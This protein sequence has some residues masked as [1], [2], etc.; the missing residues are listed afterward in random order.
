MKRS[1]LILVIALAMPVALAVA[2]V[3]ADKP[4]AKP[5]LSFEVA[6]VK[7]AGP[8]DPQKIMSGQQ[9]I[10]MESDDARVTIYSMTLND[11]V[12]IA[13]K[14]KPYQISGPSWLSSGMGAD[15]FEVRAT[16]PEGGK[17]D[18]VPE[19]MQTLLVERFGLRFHREKAEQNVYALVVGKNGLK[20]KD[21]VPD[22][23]TDV[24]SAP[25]NPS[26]PSIN[27]NGAQ[28]KMEGNPQTGMTVRGGGAGMG[29]IKMTMNGNTMHMENPKMNMEMFMAML[30]RFV[31]RP[32][33]DTTDLKGF[34]Q[35]TIDISMEEMMN[36][37]RSM[38]AGPMVAGPRAAAAGGVPGGVPAGP[39]DAASEPGGSIFQ[40]VQRLGLKLEPRKAPVD[41]IVIDSLERLAGGARDEHQARLLLLL[42]LALQALLLGGEGGLRQAEPRGQPL[43]G[44]VLVVV[45]R[46][47]AH[48]HQ[49][50][51]LLLHE[52]LQDGRDHH[53]VERAVVLHQDAPVGAHGQRGA[54]LG[55]RLLR[56]D[57]RD[58]HLAAVLLLEPKPL[59]DGDL[60]EGIHLVVHAFG[61][62]ARSVGLHLDLRLGVLDALR[63]DQDLEGHGDSLTL[64]STRNTRS[65]LLHSNVATIFD[66]GR[67]PGSR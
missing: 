15:R 10:G 66:T 51:L 53:R 40:S 11:L 34:Y 57:A 35:I 41:K 31:D 19:M 49:V 33:V 30:S 65:S 29:P 20:L 61:D 5:A 28:V 4:A 26:V 23:A 38:G 62:D 47:L 45:D 1:V 64:E 9:R 54:D 6:S 22:E 67:H 24:P 50:R 16:I 44:L 13:F 3:S 63:R 36:A 18:Q 14:A 39:A 42:R 43:A 37:A 32:I 25:P 17:K 21:A 60:V 7:P 55:H 8:L 56:A 59:L 27:V 52:L 48:E 58:D 46:L 2:Q 12:M